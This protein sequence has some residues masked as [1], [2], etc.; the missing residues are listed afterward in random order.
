VTIHKD[1]NRE[2]KDAD[3][4][5]QKKK[6]EKKGTRIHVEWE[7]GASVKLIAAGK[8]QGV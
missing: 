1:R 8:T 4:K 5:F 3:Y 2:E 6:A 7:G